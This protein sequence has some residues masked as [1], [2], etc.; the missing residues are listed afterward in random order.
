MNNDIRYVGMG[1]ASISLLGISLFAS[2]CGGPS[3]REIQLEQQVAQYQKKDDEK[4]QQEIIKS[5][6]SSELAKHNNNSQLADFYSKV[7]NKLSTTNNAVAE[8]EKNVAGIKVKESE[9]ESKA[10][11]SSYVFSGSS[12][13]VIWPRSFDYFVPIVPY[14]RYEPPHINPPYVPKPA[15]H[16][17]PRRSPEPIPR[18]PYH[19][20]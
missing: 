7:D 10:S 9:L 2:G 3:A 12:Y 13:T 8:L 11:S 16:P 20:R 14:P 17:I 5:A 1:I 18:Q 4:R 6:V 19:P 15:P